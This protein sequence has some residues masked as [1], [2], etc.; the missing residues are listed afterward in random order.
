MSRYYKPNWL[1][2]SLPYLYVL[3]GCATLYLLPPPWSIV[4]GG[5]L[6][7]SG[8]HVLA[9]RQLERRRIR[10]EQLERHSRR[11]PA[12]TVDWGDAR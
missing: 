5:L 8:A 10:A 12:R 3:A 2:E 4:S 1:Y 9:M 7:L 6:L 11:M